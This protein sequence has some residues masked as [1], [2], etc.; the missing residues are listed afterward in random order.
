MIRFGSSD[1]DPIGLLWRQLRQSPVDGDLWFQL[2]REY[3]LAQL[4]WQA[5]YGLRQARRINPSITQ[6]EPPA[7][8]LFEQR[9]DLDADEVLAQTP[10]PGHDTRISEF[11]DWLLRSPGDWLTWLYLGRLLELEPQDAHPAH[12]PTTQTVVQQ[13]VALEPIAGESQHWLGVWR[14]NSGDGP[15]AVAAF[16]TLLQIRPV[17][18][19]SMMFLGEALLRT[20]QRQAAEKSFTRASL[21]S[22][23]V[24]LRELA[25]RVY[26]HNYWNEALEL[27]VKALQID[28]DNVATL[29]AMLTIHWEVFNL[30]EVRDICARI[31]MLDPGNDDVGYMLSAL[32]GRMGDAKGHFAAVQAKYAEVSIGDPT[33]RLASS[34][35][36]ASLYQDDL[37]A[38]EI[39]DLHRQL[40]APIEDALLPHRTNFLVIPRGERLKIGFV[41]GD[42]HRQHPVNLFMLPVLQNL[43]HGRLEVFIYNTGSMQDEYTLMTK[44]CADHWIEAGRLDDNRLLQRI[45]TDHVEVLLDLAG[46]TS[47]HRLG[48]FTMRAAPVQ[49]TFL[50]YP[51]S[52]GLSTMDWLIG[53]RWVSPCEHHSLFSEGLA[54]LPSS[55]FCWAPVDS[56]PLPQQRSSGASVVF[57]SFNN[58]MKLSPRTLNLWAKV[59]HAVPGSRLLLKAPSLRDMAVCDRF[60]LLLRE[61]R[62]DSSRLE[63]QGPSELGEM[64]QAYGEIDIALDPTPYNGGTTSLQALWMG[65]PMVS[66]LGGNFASRMGASFL[67]SLGRSE[68]LAESDEEYVGIARD[69]AARVEDL[70]VSR[71]KFREQMQ[72]SPLCDLERY[73]CDFELLLERMWHCYEHGNCERL[74]RL[75]A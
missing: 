7:A 66:L 20:G 65:V 29:Q 48:L 26:L 23:P 59:L 40:V 68:W 6:G 19:G 72:A 9:L 56:Y 18:Y 51:H 64:M 53:D 44:A 21:S 43:D 8:S 73:V 28:P 71:H 74:I 60:R 38:A 46:H 14:L 57:G 50:G 75:G 24:F 45:R 49:A 70:R 13:A 42:F 36:M 37:P 58:V 34:I 67:Y 31:L 5:S 63:F 41:S 27:L 3:Q 15:G 1:S 17:R 2:F 30:S 4:A 69:L 54:Q 35:A 10:G 55:V 52:T 62:I 12:W 61:R 39:A 25:Q 22:N 16:S 11:L 32:P 33:S 47:G